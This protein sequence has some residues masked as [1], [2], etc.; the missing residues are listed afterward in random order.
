VLK[1]FIVLILLAYSCTQEQIKL[2]YSTECTRLKIV[3]KDSFKESYKTKLYLTEHKSRREYTL[4]NDR[5]EYM[6]DLLII[7]GD[8]FNQP[9][10]ITFNNFD[11]LSING[12]FLNFNDSF[13]FR[14]KQISRGASF[15]VYDSCY[16]RKK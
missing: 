16:C 12:R 10:V 7:E 11:T 6:S 14:S 13:Y 1:N 8:S 2:E 4:F 15:I 9:F 3:N 5:M